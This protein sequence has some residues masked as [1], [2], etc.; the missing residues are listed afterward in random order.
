MADQ[1][2]ATGHDGQPVESQS[3][4]EKSVGEYCRT[5][6]STLKPPMHK[7]PNPITL[8]RMLNGK[9]WLFF[10]VGFIAWV[11]L[12]PGDTVEFPSL[13]IMS[14]PGMHSISSQSVLQS[15][16]LQRNLIKPLRISHG[17]SHWFSC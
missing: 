17:V 4:E 2:G 9:Q 11:C 7:A 8:L 6:V 13:T 5:R 1:Y 3:P 12:R 16:I 15:L 14:R 10:L